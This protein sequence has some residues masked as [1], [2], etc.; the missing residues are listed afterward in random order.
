MAKTLK[1][2]KPKRGKKQRKSS[3]NIGKTGGMLKFLLG[4]KSDFH[5]LVDSSNLTPAQRDEAIRLKRQSMMPTNINDINDSKRV[6]EV[7]TIQRLK[8]MSDREIID[9]AKYKQGRASR[10]STS[11]ISSDGP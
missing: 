5:K 3:K 6:K 10:G 9:E 11:R 4:H 2:R 1:N 8:A 7:A